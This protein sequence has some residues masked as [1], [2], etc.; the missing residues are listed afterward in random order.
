[1]STNCIHCIKNERTGPD[2]LCDECRKAENKKKPWR[3][4]AKKRYQRDG[5]I[6]IDDNAEVSFGDDPGAYVQAWVWVPDEDANRSAAARACVEYTR[7]VMAHG[8]KVREFVDKHLPPLPKD[9]E[10]R[11]GG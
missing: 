3:E 2:L 4:A 7:H 1:M 5:E 6:E 10:H 8:C 11:V 9:E